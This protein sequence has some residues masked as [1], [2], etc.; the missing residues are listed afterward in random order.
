MKGTIGVA[1]R[2]KPAQGARSRRQ[3]AQ[4]TR[5][6]HTGPAWPPLPGRFL[7]CLPP[8]TAPDPR[9]SDPRFKHSKDVPLIGRLSMPSA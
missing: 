2:P 6:G 4:G 9:E 8:D 7:T 3:P 5:A 1:W